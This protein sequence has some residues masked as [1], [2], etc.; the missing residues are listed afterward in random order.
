MGTAAGKIRGW[1]RT[2]AGGSPREAGQDSPSPRKA[3]AITVAPVRGISKHPPI[4]VRIDSA[5]WRTREHSA[6]GHVSRAHHPSKIGARSELH[7]RTLEGPLE[8]LDPFG[9]KETR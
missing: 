1:I 5:I 7:V 9:E 4:R 3:V 8:G 6:H 2:I